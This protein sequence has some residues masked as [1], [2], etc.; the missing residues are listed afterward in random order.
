MHGFG[1]EHH[2]QPGII[3]ISQTTEMGTVYT[4]EEIAAITKFAHSFNLKVH[5]D[6]ARISN[7]A[8]SLNAGFREFTRDAGIDVLSFGGTKNGLMYGEAVIFFDQG[9]C[10]DFK[11]R[12]KQGMQLAS[13]MR[14]I[15]AQFNAYLEKELWKANA[16]H[17][18]RMAES[19]YQK[20]K[21]INGITI[22][23]EVQANAVFVIIPP[24]IAD[25]LQNE[26]FFYPWDESRNEYRWMTSY[27]TSEKDIEDFV[28]K[29]RELLN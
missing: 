9:L 26:Y 22:T 10:E 6:G 13:K 19:L 14:F 3:S 16:A 18:N 21:D 7:A 5:M 17:A 24:Q 11:Y 1:F 25:K 28:A 20:V 23:Q 4:P 15:A 8:V 27:D 29:L 2:S 12:R